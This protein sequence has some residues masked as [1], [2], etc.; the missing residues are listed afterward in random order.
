MKC[1][2]GLDAIFGVILLQI[3]QS[4]NTFDLL[5]TFITHIEYELACNFSGRHAN[6]QKQR[7]RDALKES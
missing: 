4:N 7:W 6:S 3:I 2:N 5:E 1:I